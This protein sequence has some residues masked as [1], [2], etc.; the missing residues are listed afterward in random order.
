MQVYTAAFSEALTN[1]Y[2]LGVAPEF[3]VW[4]VCRNRTTGD[5]QPIGIWT[6]DD[7]ITIQVTNQEGVAVTRTYLGGVGLD[8]GTISYVLDLTSEPVD[9][10]FAP[11]TDF[12]NQAWRLWDMRLANT[13]IHVTTRNAGDVLILPPQMQYVGVVDTAPLSVDGDEGAAIALTVRSEMLWQLGLINPAKTSDEYQRRR[14]ATD[15]FCLYSNLNRKHNW[16]K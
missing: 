3:F 16:G 12:A 1:A 6:G 4:F 13:E 8:V 14:L 9:I 15:T 7:D 2:D 11:F 10:R 5:P